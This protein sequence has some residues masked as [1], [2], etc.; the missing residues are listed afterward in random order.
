VYA[1]RAA[2]RGQQQPPPSA[3]SKV[4]RL[5]DDTICINALLLWRI[6]KIKSEN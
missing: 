5:L 4:R 6:D 3:D 2:I 1:K